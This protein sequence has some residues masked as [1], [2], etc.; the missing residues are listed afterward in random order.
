MQP[1]LNLSCVNIH[2]Y[3]GLQNVEKIANFINLKDKK[4]QTVLHDAIHK[5]FLQG[6]K[7]LLRYGSI[8]KTVNVAGQTAIDLLQLKEAA[9]RQKATIQRFFRWLGKLF[10]LVSPDAGMCTIICR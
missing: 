1:V 2:M 8:A 9:I 5:D 4:G 10:G 7:L 3:T 6:M